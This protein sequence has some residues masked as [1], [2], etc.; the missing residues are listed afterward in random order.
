M[1]PTVNIHEKAE[2][3]CAGAG[4]IVRES[5]QHPERVGSFR[6]CQALRVPCVSGVRRE[7]PRKV[8]V[9][10]KGQKVRSSQAGGMVNRVSPSREKGRSRL[11][12]RELSTQEG[13]GSS[14]P[15][16]VQREQRPRSDWETW[17]GARRPEP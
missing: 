12:C 10:S 6:D 17:M 5:R 8:E 14:P 7:K 2:L 15:R 11:S 13:L 3:R 1:I 16:P 4:M 9:S